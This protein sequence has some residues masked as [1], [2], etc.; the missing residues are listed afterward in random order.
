[1]GRCP[2]HPRIDKDFEGHG[3]H[4]QGQ[5]GLALETPLSLLPQSKGLSPSQLMML[6]MVPSAL[7]VTKR[8]LKAGDLEN[9]CI[10]QAP[11]R[12]RESPI[13]ISPNPGPQA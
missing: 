12:V 7:V 3:G 10:F 5:V 8:W 4:C 2:R 1:M 9:P 6:L 13:N 11:R